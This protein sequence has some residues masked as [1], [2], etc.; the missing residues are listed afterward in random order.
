MLIVRKFDEITPNDGATPLAWHEAY[1]GLYV[2]ASGDVALT[3]AT[4]DEILVPAIMPGVVY[5]QLEFTRVKLTG[6]TATGIY[7][8]KGVRK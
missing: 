3:L 2:E 6:T 5:G 1:E 4:G 8:V 7:G